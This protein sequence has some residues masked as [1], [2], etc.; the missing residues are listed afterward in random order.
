MFNYSCHI[1][2]K[3]PY[4]TESS[5]YIWSQFFKLNI[6]VLN[7]YIIRSVLKANLN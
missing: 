5:F 7:I 4:L 3:E 2:I 6:I 1:R